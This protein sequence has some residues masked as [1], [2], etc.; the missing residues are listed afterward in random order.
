MEPVVRES[1]QPGLETHSN[2]FPPNL[3]DET[4]PDENKVSVAERNKKRILGLKPR[5]FFIMIGLSLV[6]VVGAAV[7][8]AVAGSRKTETKPSTTNSRPE[9]AANGSS[10]PVP[11]TIPD[12]SNSTNPTTLSISNLLVNSKLATVNWTDSKNYQHHALFYQNRTG[13]LTLS[14]WDSENR[15]WAILPVFVPGL[16]IDATLNGTAIAASVDNNFQLNVYFYSVKQEIKEFYT[17][18]QQARVWSKGSLTDHNAK[19]F[20]DSQLTA[21]NQLCASHDCCNSTV[22]LYQDPNQ[23]LRYMNGS[24]KWYVRLSLF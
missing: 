1:N 6:L 2:Y 21:Y 4:Q 3:E 15:T 5:A 14:L 18:D 19:G 24:D 12:V 20:P 11:G 23:Q 16:Q 22:V 13:S 17:K 8:G 10:T 7:G 9:P